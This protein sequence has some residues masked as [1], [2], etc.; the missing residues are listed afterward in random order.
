MTQRQEQF[1]LTVAEETGGSFGWGMFNVS[2]AA[3]ML[4]QAPVHA[5]AVHAREIESQVPGKRMRAVR[6]P[7]G[8]NVRHRALE[9]RP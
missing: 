7:A 8:V 5:A 4:R 1:A 9:T 2:L 3:G 6:Q